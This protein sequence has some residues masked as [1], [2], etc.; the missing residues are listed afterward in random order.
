M[1]RPAL[2]L[3]ELSDGGIVRR[4]Y[5][6]LRDLDWKMQIAYLPADERCFLR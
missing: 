5:G 2:A 6:I 3:N 4:Y 1:E